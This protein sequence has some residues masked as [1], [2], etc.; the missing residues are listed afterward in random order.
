MTSSF[1]KFVSG[2]S[3]IAVLLTVSGPVSVSAY[4]AAPTLAGS[5][6]SSGIIQLTWN[7]LPQGTK[8]S[9]AADNGELMGY[10]VFLRKASDTDTTWNKKPFARLKMSNGDYD[11]YN[12]EN[13]PS[14]TYV[15][16]VAAYG[17]DVIGYHFDYYTNQVTVQV[18]STVNAQ[19]GLPQT[20]YPQTFLPANI[21]GNSSALSLTGKIEDCTLKYNWST[22]PDSMKVEGYAIFLKNVSDTDENW[23]IKPFGLL[24]KAYNNYNYYNLSGMPFG[25]YVAKIAKYDYDV[26]GYKFDN[27]S[28]EVTLNLTCG[29]APVSA[30]ALT[31]PT[32]LQPTSQQVLTNYPRKATIQWSPV[33][34]AVSYQVAIECDICGSSLW[35]S[36]YPIYSSNTAS[37]VTPALAGDNT[38]RVRVRAL[39]ASDIGPWSDFRLFSYVTPSTSTTPER[40]KKQAMSDRQQSSSDATLSLAVTSWVQNHP[41]F[42]FGFWN[43]NDKAPMYQQFVIERYRLRGRARV[44][45][46]KRVFYIDKNDTTFLDTS[47]QEGVTYYYRVSAVNYLANG[48]A[49]T[50]SS[51]NSLLVLPN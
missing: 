45:S 15:A 5:V 38:F 48:K 16:Q 44:L 51:S 41:L 30:P 11:Y 29:T 10:A 7:A 17:Y 22:L 39:S 26:I 21:A 23:S 3:F 2:L 32:I 50:Q 8:V 49:R 28:N 46:S 47:A 1:A 42:T 37:F 43:G 35:E 27:Y 33:N 12:L 31:A 4:T 19:S 20:T 34:G 24:R 14:G 18:G 6:N 40:S 36:K 25:T 13:M 9:A